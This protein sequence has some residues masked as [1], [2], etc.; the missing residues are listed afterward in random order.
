[1]RRSKPGKQHAFSLIEL[2]IVIAII[3]ILAAVSYPSY[4][5]YVLRTYRTEATTTLLQLANNQAHYLA[6]HGSYTAD[7]AV[8]GA[9]S[10]SRY[11]FEV[12]LSEQNQAYEIRAL[13]QGPQQADAP[14]SLFTLNHLGQRNQL[15][16]QTLSCWD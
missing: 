7:L 15:S 3:G 14:C 11:T 1:M 4:Q 8:L 2:L 16:P 9:A 6:D 12:L 10:S 13:A 5:Q